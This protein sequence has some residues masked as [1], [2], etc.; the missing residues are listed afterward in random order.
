MR[1]L[2]RAQPPEVQSE[3]RAAFNDRV[4][5]YA[6]ERGVELPVSVKIAVGV[7]PSRGS[8]EG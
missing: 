8:S 7:R 2:V 6:T 5:R 1:A 3:I 4:L